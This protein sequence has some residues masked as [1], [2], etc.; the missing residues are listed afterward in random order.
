L[1]PLDSRPLFAAAGILLVLTA[2]AFHAAGS[3]RDGLQAQLD[4]RLR[5]AVELAVVALEEEPYE[6][7]VALERVR[8]ATG[9]SEIR[10]YDAQ[11]R[12]AGGTPG[13]GT[14]PG[15]PREIR[16]RA[17]DGALGQPDPSLRAPEEDAGGGLTLVVPVTSIPGTG[18]V[19]ARLDRGALGAL[20]AAGLLFQAAKLL[21]GAVALAGALILL[22]WLL[23]AP[24]PAA[25]R[26]Q[27]ASSDVEV[28][29]GTVREVM[30]TLKDAETEA[31]DRRTAAEADAERWRR[32]S[33][34]VL[35]SLT[36]GVVAFDP[37]GRVTMFN[38]AAEEILAVPARRAHGRVLA[39]VLGGEDP[40][41]HVAAR[42]LELGRPTDGL[43]AA[44]TDADGVTRWL[45][46]GSTVLRGDDGA[47]T[48]GILLIADLTETK[49]L[50][51]QMEL[52]DRLSAVGEM[53][54]GIAHEIKNSLHSLMGF[55]NLLREDFPD[56][57]PLP[58]RGILTEVEALRGTVHAVLEFSRPS[59][60]VKEPARVDGLVED[61]AASVAEAARETGVE[62]VVDAGPELPAVPVDA[63]AIRRAFLNLARNAVEAMPDG[64]SLTISTRATE[65]GEGVRVAFR[66]TGPGIPEADRATVFTPFYTTKREGSGLGLALVHK[67]VT[68]HGGRLVLLSREGVGAEFIVHLPGGEA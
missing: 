62:I 30:T 28:V 6:L 37:D 38:R 59:S 50:R 12:L 55:A 66:D 46:L 44:R 41:T 10:L 51:D 42:L 8:V 20:P 16:L 52:K 15:V 22:R 48:G 21:A 68:D 25:A 2:V 3:L 32:M 64:G 67:T 61:V 31:H 36:S 24:V 13:A 9:C 45:G 33:G 56:E 1:S 49:R 17:G 7:G 53:A 34:L 47:D 18:A 63:E 23:R 65:T 58:V 60:L 27:P 40:V 57:P 26:A 14:G 29:L 5:T 11:G 54:A 35:Q 19:L 4:G 39:D 43:E